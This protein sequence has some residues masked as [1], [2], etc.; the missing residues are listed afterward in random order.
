MDIV[1]KKLM[2]VTIGAL[3]VNELVLYVELKFLINYT[4][5]ESCQ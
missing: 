5:N 1:G 4:G 3:R 2:L